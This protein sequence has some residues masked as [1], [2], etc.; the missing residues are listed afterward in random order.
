AR[1]AD[2]DALAELADIRARLAGLAGLDWAG[3]PGQVLLDGLRGLG[4]LTRQLEAVRA[5]V[6]AAAKTDASW[7]LD[8]SKS[9]P[10]WLERHTGASIA[11]CRRQ[12]RTAVRL[13]QH[14]PATIEALA[15][16]RVGV[17]HCTILV[18]EVVRTTRMSEQ[19]HSREIGEAFLLEQATQL[20]ADA[21]AMVAKSWAIGAD[22]DAA[23]RAWR[24][25]GAKEEVF[26]SPT[27]GGYHLHGFIGEANGRVCDQALAAMMGRRA[28]G[29]E[30]RPA[31]RRAAALVALLGE[32]LS[33]GRLQPSARIPRQIT[34][35]VPYDTFKHL[36]EACRSAR[37]RDPKTR[38]DGKQGTGSGRRAGEPGQVFGGA[39]AAGGLAGGNPGADEAPVLSDAEWA[40]A[41]EPGFDGDHVISTRL[42]HRKLRGIDPAT[43]S[44]GTPIPPA[45]L[46]R[47]ACGSQL[48]RIVFGPDSTVLDVGRAKRIFPANQVKAVIARDRHCQYPG[49]HEP[50]EF[51]EIH[52]SL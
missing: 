4:Q 31:E 15:Q 11:A 48:S 14:L 17:D 9:L 22:P 30:R 29:D 5:R 21:F 6:T 8:G 35:H 12:V 46:A 40:A 43:F 20:D 23:D 33:A 13:T 3:A 27:M 26:L 32:A 45:L 24:D 28:E 41:W 1:V 50:P 7:A 16:G 2:A 51:A 18:R 44:D 49:C 36:I 52:H 10:T 42:D 37:P 34:M 38:P 39:E 25:E 19:L 47:L